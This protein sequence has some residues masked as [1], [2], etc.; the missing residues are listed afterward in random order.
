MKIQWLGHACFRL[1]SEGGSLVLDPYEDNRVPG[2]G[3]MRAEAD[4]VLSSHGHGDHNAVE[5]ITLT[6]RDCGL[7][8]KA[9][10]CFHDEKGGALRGENL[11]HIISDGSVTVG[12]C[13]DLG[14]FP[15]G[16]L[17]EALKGLDAL[18][19]PVGGYY[20]IDAETANALVEA[21]KPRVVIPMHYRIEGRFGYKEIGT[22]EDF[23]AL[24]SDVVRCKGS[25]LDL[26]KQTPA[27]T[28]VPEL[29]K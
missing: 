10:P 24:R 5:T 18:M 6:G 14:H 12:H 17:L 15:E 20:T 28:A 23:L 11:I 29:I 19:I 13:G 8:V 4:A 22:L 7:Q 9:L 25:E 26:T 3:I 16:E 2:V 1:E 27:Q 21:V